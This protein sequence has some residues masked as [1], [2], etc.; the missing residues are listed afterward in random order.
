MLP[1]VLVDLYYYGSPLKSTLLRIWA[2]SKRVRIHTGLLVMERS[3]QRDRLVITKYEYCSDNSRPCGVDLPMTESL[4]GCWG[5][6]GSWKHIYSKI[7]F[8]ER[9]L[10][11]RST[12]CQTELHL[13]IFLGPR[14][15]VQIHGAHVAIEDWDYDQGRFT[16]DPARMV[17][18]RVS[19]RFLL[20]YSSILLFIQALH[21]AFSVKRST[22]CGE[23]RRTVDDCWSRAVK[24]KVAR[25]VGSQCTRLW[26]DVDALSETYLLY[27]AYLRRHIVSKFN[28]IMRDSRVNHRGLSHKEAMPSFPWN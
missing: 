3:Q 5:K 22:R 15:V 8:G 27:F 12:C 19:V 23:A 4:C 28:N 11:L 2:K 13:A 10:Y 16:F 26:L 6:G 7:K 1:E 24:G 17:V 14:R 9:F 25:S 20:L 21:I 18:M